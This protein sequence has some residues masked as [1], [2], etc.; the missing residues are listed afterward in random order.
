VTTPFPALPDGFTARA[1]TL[2]DAAIVAELVAD[3]EEFE[4]GEREMTE[5]DIRAFWQVP[6]LDLADASIGVFA[7]D[8]L[9]A[10][11]DVRDAY[12]EVDV[13]PE[14]RGRGIGTAL[15]PWTWAR[16]RAQGADHVEQTFSDARTD[17]A[18]LFRAHGYVSSWSSWLFRMP[19]TD[20]RVPPLPDGYAVTPLDYAAD[21]REAFD[22]IRVAFDEWRERPGETWE[23]WDGFLGNHAYL[24]PADSSVLR[25]DGRIVGIAIA[26]DYGPGTDPWIQQLAV[27]R[28]HRGKGLGGA[29]I[30]GTFAPFAE[31]GRTHGAL[32]TDSRSGARE[33]Y[34]H[35]GFTVRTSA[36]HWEKRLN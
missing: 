28:E 5:A 1:H 25:H 14:F 11:G 26:M 7:G 33:M 4:D 2:D 16:A 36:T 8:R 31:R 29:L 6:G 32:G 21:A 30:K 17:G 19:I 3:C 15:L 24:A 18:A 27:A 9:A 20:L 22:V 12:A 13:H 34:E 10:T 23:E 35:L